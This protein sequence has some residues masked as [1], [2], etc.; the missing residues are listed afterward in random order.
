MKSVI[1][2]IFLSAAICLTAM[3]A[4]AILPN[5]ASFKNETN[6]TT[7]LNNLLIKAIQI[8]D[9]QARVAAIGREFVGVPY[10]AGTLEGSPETLKI[11]L[12]EMD[13][14]TFV[15]TVLTIA[16]T[17]GERRSSWRDFVYNL[18]KIRYRGGSI[19]GYASR[20]HYFSD[21]VVDNVHRGTIKEYTTRMPANDWTVKT[22][23][24]MS[25]NRDKYEALSD[26]TEFERIKSCEIGYRNHRYP[27]IKTSKITNKA[28]VAALKEGDVVA[29][30]TKTPGLD[31]TH[32]GI[33][34]KKDGVPHLMHASSKHGKII[35]DELP[36]ADY[37]RKNGSTGI[38]VIRLNE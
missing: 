36:L 15:E 10:V 23:D 6:D 24:F 29:L 8:D 2:K 32:M 26:S 12:D 19:N 27:Y 16:Y 7:K 4:H 14:T 22:L 11:N 13:C 5:E 37:L 28:I 17:A 35:I 3:E 25:S 18:E 38:R 21:W 20:L 9:P 30:T 31:V 1:T 33:I 34:I